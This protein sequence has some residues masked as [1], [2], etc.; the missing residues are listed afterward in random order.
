MILSSRNVHR[1]EDNRKLACCL[2]HD[3]KIDK[4]A[5]NNVIG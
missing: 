2:K 3:L 5:K 1:K 4:L